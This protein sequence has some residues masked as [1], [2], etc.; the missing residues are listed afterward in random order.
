MVV[1]GHC[2]PIR[3]LH[4]AA[5]PTSLC[6]KLASVVERIDDGHLDWF[7]R[8]A[9]DRLERIFGPL[10]VIDP[11]GG[12]RGVHDLEADLPAGMVAA[13][14]VTSEVEQA[15][16]GLV[17]SADRRL[18]ALRIPGSD[19]SWQVGLS[20]RAKVNSISHVAVISLLNDLEDQGRS[21]AIAGD[22][23]DPFTARLWELGI[24]SVYGWKAKPGCGGRVTVCAGFYSGREWGR[25]LIDAWLESF[26]RTRRGKNKLDKLARAD[27]TERHL[28]IV[29]DP[30][31]QA[32]T[33]I[34][35]GLLTWHEE[36]ANSDVMPSCSPPE[37]LTHMWLMPLF[38]AKEAF[39]WTR[40]S[41][42][43]VRSFEKSVT[44]PSTGASSFRQELSCES[45]PSA[46]RVL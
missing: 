15:R 44:D 39:Y 43:R 26:F 27:A 28:V 18:S 13:I 3:L 24:E 22:W 33:G 2:R 8:Q 30:F 16:A 21:H 20:A 17:A 14:E 4:F 38:G 34:S 37:P 12:P 7:E 9:R 1:S 40:R 42:W 11:G 25:A 6:G 35:L 31:S 23:R 41:G 5:A 32:G 19:Y 29:L 45:L 46:A 10:R 36:G